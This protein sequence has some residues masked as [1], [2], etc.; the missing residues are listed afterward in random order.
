MH[1]G[2][3]TNAPATHSHAWTKFQTTR[4]ERSRRDGMS[5]GC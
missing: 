4:Y 3:I 2:S 5:A 1:S